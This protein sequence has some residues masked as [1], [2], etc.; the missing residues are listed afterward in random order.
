MDEGYL[1]INNNKIETF[2]KHNKTLRSQ[3]I[4]KEI[5]VKENFQF[6]YCRINTKKS[7]VN[8]KFK[9]SQNS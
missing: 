9:S 3:E 2:P 6:V 1:E 7:K 8:S 5:E 4:N